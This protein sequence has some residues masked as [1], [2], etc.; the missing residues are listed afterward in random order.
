MVIPIPK[1]A[2][3]DPE[4]QAVPI[5]AEATIDSYPAAE[6][7][8]VEK[9][10]FF[11]R[12][13]FA[14]ETF[15][16]LN[17]IQTEPARRIPGTPS[18]N[19]AIAEFEKR[20]RIAQAAGNREEAY[21]NQ[22]RA[23]VLRSDIESASQV[24][25]P[26]A[27]GTNLALRGYG[28]IKSI[29]R[30]VKTA[31]TAVPSAWFGMEGAKQAAIPKQPG[32]TAS[33][34]ALRVGSGTGQAMLG[35]LGTVSGTADSLRR[36]SG[37]PSKP[38]PPRDLDIAHEYAGLGGKL[39]AQKHVQLLEN[40]V[41]KHVNPLIEAV[42]ASH[43]EGSISKAKTVDT[44]FN[45]IAKYFPTETRAGFDFP[46]S[47]RVIVK[48]LKDTPGDSMT[49]DQA[50][51]LRSAIGK[52]LNKVHDPASK[53][54]LSAAYGNLTEQM[55]AAAKEVG[56][57]GSF[58]QYNAVT[59]KLY[60]PGGVALQDAAN[61]QSGIEV[62]KALHG[63]RGPVKV[64]LDEMKSY[65]SKPDD[66]SSL[67]EAYKPTAN[68]R[69]QK[70]LIDHWWARHAAGIATS[71][72]GMG[73]LPGYGGIT[74]IQAIRDLGKTDIPIPQ[75][76]VRLGEKSAALNVLPPPMEV[77][78][79]KP[80]ATP[81]AETKVTTPV[82]ETFK[83]RMSRMVA[84]EDARRT[85]QPTVTEPPE[86]VSAPSEQIT[87]EPVV[88]SPLKSALRVRANASKVLSY[89]RNPG[90]FSREAE[91]QATEF[92]RDNLDIDISQ[93][94][95]LFEAEKGLLDLSRG[96]IKSKSAKTPQNITESAPVSPPVAPSPTGKSASPP[97]PEPIVTSKSPGMPIAEAE[98]ALPAVVGPKL[99][100][101]Y[102]NLES[103]THKSLLRKA[104]GGIPVKKKLEH[105][106][107]EVSS[108]E[109]EHIAWLETKGY[110]PEELKLLAPAVKAKLLFEWRKYKSQKSKE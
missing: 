107:R 1:N 7:G 66:I 108:T 52:V 18:V 82:A 81:P 43:P 33:E 84:E 51:S 97:A 16:K 20:S 100:Q 96:K 83:E 76:A 5:P 40:E 2:R 34:Y 47:V 10:G 12:G 19:E 37:K 32:E 90:K 13:T 23:D 4:S 57:E 103:E 8:E 88:E 58:N 22:S 61:A 35:S 94:E 89:L 41:S 74:A 11:R 67:I 93:G 70:S 6:I 26:L 79:P 48:E 17:Y 28:A 27:L 49:F 9:P 62:L 44:L 75:E 85:I 106:S 53:A 99:A 71:L 14:P 36:T 65:G 60:S 69:L 25:S 21:A 15:G 31:M 104:R 56:M 72:V 45:S 91:T 102:A 80:I 101:E 3:I 105:E 29:P 110:T 98:T 86:P 64:L 92:I 109:T 30:L 78:T 39:F 73:H 77:P 59:R 63:E 38:A 95:N 42:N 87:P 68:H 50:K 46:N 54:P 55:R 24:T